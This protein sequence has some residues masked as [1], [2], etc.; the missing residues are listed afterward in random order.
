MLEDHTASNIYF[1]SKYMGFILGIWSM[2]ALNSKLLTSKSQ[3]QTTKHTK[4]YRWK[5]V[6]NKQGQKK[7]QASHVQMKVLCALFCPSYF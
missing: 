2:V 6:K 3:F 7:L 1:L 5:H 4:A